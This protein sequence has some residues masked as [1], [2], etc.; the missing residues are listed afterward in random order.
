MQVGYYICDGSTPV[1]FTQVWQ[2]SPQAE[3]AM[4]TLPGVPSTGTHVFSI[5]LLSGTT[6]AAYM[7]GT[8]VGSYN[9]GSSISSSSYPI[10]ALSEEDG[11]A[12][13]IS[14]PTTSFQ[15]AI[16]ALVNGVWVDP[17]SISVYN[18]GAS[19]GLQG[20]AQNPLMTADSFTVGGLLPI[21]SNGSP[22]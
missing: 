12:A 19:W 14:I 3:L 18:D 2:L 21:P 5:R 9:L 15:V 4:Y 8:E 16:Q 22:L 20:P 7:D 1:V 6:W 11:L 17:A 13:P 10:Y